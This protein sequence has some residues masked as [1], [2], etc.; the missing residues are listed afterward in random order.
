MNFSQSTVF[1]IIASFGL[2]IIN[3]IISV[4]EARV[5]GPEELGRFQ[6]YI[7]TQTYVAT[8]CALGIGQSCI[9]FINRLNFEERKVISTSVNFSLI[10]SAITGVI[11]ITVIF[12]NRDYFG[13]DAV[14]FI[15][16]F[17]LGTSAT[18][19]NNIFTPVLL[20]RMEVVRNQVV[21]YSSRIITFLAL[22]LLL[23]FKHQL[24]VGFLIGLTGFTNIL[25]SF[26]L[27]YYFRERFSFKDG[28]DFSL[29]KKIIF[30]GIKLSGNNI[31]SITLI[32]LPIYF[33]TLF[34]IGDGL[35]SVGYYSRANTLLVIGTVIASTIGPLLYSKWSGTSDEKLQSQVRRFSMFYIIINLFLAISLIITAP[36]LIRILYGKDYVVAIPL[37]QILA[38]SLIGNGIKEVCYGILS[39]RGFP[40]KILKNLCFGIF[41]TSIA[42]YYV[43]PLYGVCG[44]SIVTLTITLLTAM[45]LMRDV[46]IISNIKYCDFFIIPS[47]D[48]IKSIFLQLFHK[49]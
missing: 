49:S 9:Y 33:L 41:I 22:S 38:L 21:K 32:S 1:S 20:T 18:L 14:F 5:L 25:S 44:C 11:L 48:S 37:L 15:C 6:V 8:L 39:S 23:L 47:K 29:L 36:L 42:D 27:Y 45:L 19:I 17:C 46:T 10:L 30:W 16:L 26:L 2:L 43:I 31:A 13:D 24:N 35:V 34:S 12:A 28:I 3:M 7:T 40:L 4:I